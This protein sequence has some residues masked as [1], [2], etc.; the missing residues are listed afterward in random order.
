MRKNYIFCFFAFFLLIISAHAQFDSP[1]SNKNSKQKAIQQNSK[2]MFNRSHRVARLLNNLSD[3]L[4]LNNRQKERL[5][6]I[7][8]KL[9][10]EKSIAWSELKDNPTRL[11]ARLQ[12]I[13]NSRNIHY[14]AILDSLQYNKY[15]RYRKQLLNTNK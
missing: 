14:K 9:E 10:H 3:S 12:E 1:I 15:L 13:E 4:L 11:Q 5:I 7:S 8:N 2:E 6:I